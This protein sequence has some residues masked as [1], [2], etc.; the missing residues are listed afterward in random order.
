MKRIFLP[1]LLRLSCRLHRYTSA[2]HGHHARPLSKDVLKNAQSL[3]KWW[4]NLK[5]AVFG[6]SS[7]LT[8]LVGGVGG[9]VCELVG[10]ADLLSDHFDSKQCRSHLI[11]RSL[12]IHLLDLP[13]TFAYR[14]REVGCHLLDFDPVGGIPK[15]WVCFLFF[16]RELVMFLPPVLVQCFGGL[17]VWVVS[18]LVE[19]RPMS[20]HFQKVRRLPLLQITDQFRLH[21]FV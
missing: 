1:I 2:T 17:F 19:N 14:S 13:P 21:K 4:S 9:L 20:P 16:L 11:R 10:W 6:L 15:H 7:S 8:P 5:S 18:P 12:A 3:H